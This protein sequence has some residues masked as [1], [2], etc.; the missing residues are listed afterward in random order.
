MKNSSHCTYDVYSVFFRCI[1]IFIKT[2]FIKRAL[3]ART[4]FFPF[5]KSIYSINDSCLSPSAY[6]RPH[7]FRQ[8]SLYIWWSTC[9]LFISTSRRGYSYSPRITHCPCIFR[10][11]T[12]WFIF[13]IFNITLGKCKIAAFWS[14]LV[15]CFSEIQKT[16]YKNWKILFLNHN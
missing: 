14:R 13:W 7:I 5:F 3:H 12:F 11:M 15:K 2:R 16:F 4:W 9:N 8:T 1:H 6:E 10:Q